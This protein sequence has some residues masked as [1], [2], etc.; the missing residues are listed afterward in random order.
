MAGVLAFIMDGV[1]I[2]ATW[3]AMMRNMMII[4]AVVFIAVWAVATPLMGN[5]GL[6]LALLV[7]LGARGFT[8]L[9]AIPARADATFGAV[10]TALRPGEG[11]A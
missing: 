8:L 1:Y 3:S 10:P 4:S 7:F 6:W 9:F 11:A 5:H 2:G